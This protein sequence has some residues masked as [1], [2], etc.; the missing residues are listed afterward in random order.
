MTSTSRSASLIVPIFATLYAMGFTNLFLRSSL[1]VLAPSLTAEMSLSPEMLSTVA[2]SFFFAYAVMQLPTGILLDRLG[3][4]RTLGGMLLFT[5]A[6][7]AIFA[8][9]Q[10]AEMLILGRIL[11]GI[12]CAGTFT[13]AFYVLNMW[14]PPDRLVVQTGAVNSFSALGTLCSATPLALLIAWIGWRSSYWVFT[15]F[16]ALLTIA[17]L[18]LMRDAAPGKDVSSSKS[19]SI[20]EL[21]AGVREAA[22]Q[23]SMWRLLVVGLPMSAASTIVGAWGAPFLKDVYGLDGVSRGNVLLGVGACSIAGHFLYGHVARYVNSIRNVILAGSVLITAATGTIAFT[24]GLPLWAVSALFCLIGLASAYPTLAHAHTRGLVPSHLVGRGVSVTNLGI[25]L[26]IALSQLAFG[27]I[28]GAFPAVAG[29]PPEVGYRWAFAAQALMAIA[30]IAV[31][32][33]I[34]DA[35]PRG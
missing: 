33:P 15:G 29:V 25:M 4:R 35:R 10:S 18:V 13:G 28:V 22:R 5:T 19:E 31:Y 34:R 6:G 11:M 9:A 24:P 2:S 23:P 17:M 26:A 14:L 27:W 32:A 7:A 16:V 20:S 30:A 3:P 1:G 8:A 12:G 21:L